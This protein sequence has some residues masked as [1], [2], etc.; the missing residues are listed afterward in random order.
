MH[1]H[2]GLGPRHPTNRLPDTCDNFRL[3]YCARILR[4]VNQMTKINTKSRER[5]TPLS[6]TTGIDVSRQGTQ[7][8][9]P[10]MT[11]ETASFIEKMAEKDSIRKKKKETKK[12]EDGIAYAA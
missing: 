7:P 2:P 9:G 8:P 11:K 10:R 1:A 12:K 4:Q 3:S 6:R 5:R